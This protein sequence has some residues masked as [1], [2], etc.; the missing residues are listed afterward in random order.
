MRWL[1]DD[2]TGLYQLARQLASLPPE[3]RAAAL[4]QHD[5][6]LLGLLEH[7]WPLHA[8]EQQLPPPGDWV[9]WLILAGRGY[10]KTRTLVETGSAMARS[11]AY[12]HIGVVADSAADYRD[13]LVENRRSGFLHV[14]PSWWRPQYEP[15]KRRLTWPNGATATLYSAEDPDQ[16]RGPEHDALLFD[17]LA[18]Y[19]Y[20]EEC[21]NMAMFGL[22]TG[23][24]PVVIV[25]TTPRP[26]K[27]VRELVASPTCVVTRGTTYDNRANLSESFFSEVVRRYEGTRIGRQELNAEILDDVPGAL[28]TRALLDENRVAEPPP[29]GDIVRCVVGVDPAVTSGSESCETGIITMALGANGHGYVLEDASCR[30]QPL[31]WGERVIGAYSAH[32]ADRVIGEVNNGGDLVEMNLRAIDP[33]VSYEAVRASRGKRARAEPVAALDEQHRIHHVGGFAELEDQMCAFL[34]E[35][36]GD[37]GND[38]VDARVWAAWSLMLDGCSGLMFT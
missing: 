33:N 5:T 24:R 13:V 23:A 3:Q 18:K 1:W 6:L 35:G 37:Q 25:A 14:G 26:I 34:P 36:G 15:S 30:L 9:V 32:A 29:P 16:L 11:G 8:R 27:I 2:R 31:A 20:A 10:G 12:H 28:W 19:Q 21:W 17:E 38:R 22:R 7:Y 4:S